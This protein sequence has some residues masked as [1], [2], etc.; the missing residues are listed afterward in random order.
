M[1]ERRIRHHQTMQRRTILHPATVRLNEMTYYS[2][3]PHV[4]LL[5]T[6][7]SS[8]GRR[9]APAPQPDSGLTNHP[10]TG[11]GGG[12]DADLRGQTR[13]G[14][15]G[16]DPAAESLDTRKEAA[17][18]LAARYRASREQLHEAGDGVVKI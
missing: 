10:S 11:T 7:T 13:D 15:Q 14:Q 3:Q 4:R 1:S 2:S 12:G 18:A 8:G 6:A 17:E 9:T 16:R 5:P